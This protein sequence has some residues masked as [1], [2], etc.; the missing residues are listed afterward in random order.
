MRQFII[1]LLLAFTLFSAPS[2]AQSWQS[3]PE[4]SA[5]WLLIKTIAERP[6]YS[7]YYTYHAIQGDTTING[8]DYK[9]LYNVNSRCDTTLSTEY[10][11][12]LR[13]DSLK[14]VYFYPNYEI[15]SSTASFSIDYNV[16]ISMDTPT[17]EIMMYDFSLEAGDTFFVDTA[18]HYIEYIGLTGPQYIVCNNT[19]TVNIC[20][21]LRKTFSLSG[22]HDSTNVSATYISPWTEG[23]G[24]S[25]GPLDFLHGLV[26]SWTN[27]ECYS[28]KTHTCD[29]C[30]PCVPVAVSG[31]NSTIHLTLYPNPADQYLYLNHSGSEPLTATVY[32]TNGQVVERFILNGQ[33]RLPT[34]TYAEG[35]YLLH[36]TN[37]A[38]HHRVKKVVVQ[39]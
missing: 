29:S 21:E 7:Y 5:R 19:D 24:S 4:D 15:D 23:L 31:Q 35:M 33:Y 37:S 16:W 1:P 11:G 17:R 32:K 30:Y 18:I 3:F 14:R 39:H 22:V 20:G 9:K 13:E 28:S 36:F 34:G 26:T 8:M 12:A 27:I 25:M 6:G 2:F 38:G 10:L